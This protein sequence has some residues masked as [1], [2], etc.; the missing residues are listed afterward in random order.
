MIAALFQ[1]AK[2]IY[3][4]FVVSVMFN[5]QLNCINTKS[6]GGGKAQ[7]TDMYQTHS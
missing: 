4:Q 7:L 3:K 5:I 1:G 6:W 2:L